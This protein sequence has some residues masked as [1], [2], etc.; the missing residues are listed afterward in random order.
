ML[1]RPMSLLGTVVTS[2]ELGRGS[3]RRSFLER[4]TRLV[5]LQPLGDEGE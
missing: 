4:I 2:L 5:L 3:S 1:G